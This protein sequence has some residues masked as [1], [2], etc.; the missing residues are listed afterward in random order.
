MYFF[1]ILKELIKR[2]LLEK[3]EI[4]NYSIFL[5]FLILIGLEVLE[6][7]RGLLLFVFGILKLYYQN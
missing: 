3:I 7:I 5:N 1:K 4:N 6:V 2:V